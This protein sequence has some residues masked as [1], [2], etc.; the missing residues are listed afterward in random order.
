MAR[1]PDPPIEDPTPRAPDSIRVGIGGW[2]FAPWRGTFYPTGLPQRRELE[3]ASR[4][5]DATEVNGTYYGAQKPETYA[6]WRDATPDGFLFSAKA[7]MRIVQSRT[8]AKTGPQVEDFI[9]GIATLDTKLGPLI[10]QFDR[11]TRVDRDDFTAFLALLPTEFDGLPLR[12][13]LDV[14][15][16]AFVDADYIAL[17]RRHGFATVFTDSP[18]HPS[19]AD[20]TAGFV[21]A[22]LMRAR[23]SEPTGYTPKELA[24]WRDRAHAWT[25]GGEPGDLSKTTPDIPRREPREVFINFIAADKVRNPAA[26]LALRTLLAEGQGAARRSTANGKVRRSR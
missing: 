23:E 14:R 4:H 13:V 6:R 10:W 26:A 19:F 8:L 22:R 3:F 25:A 7:P 11:G 16:P 5:L 9:G 20:I 24:A 12:H 1:K 15:D 2:D 21:Y 18:D 17:V